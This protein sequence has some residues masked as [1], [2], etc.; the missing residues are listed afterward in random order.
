MWTLYNDKKKEPIWPLIPFASWPWLTFCKW[1]FLELDLTTT[2]RCT[3]G[4][5]HNKTTFLRKKRKH[6]HARYPLTRKGNMYTHTCVEVIFS[7]YVMLNL[8]LAQPIIKR[9]W[10]YHHMWHLWLEMHCMY[11]NVGHVYKIKYVSNSFRNMYVS[12]GKLCMFNNHFRQGPYFR[13]L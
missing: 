10:E 5:V 4:N 11:M 1:T 9:L 7:W 6:K 2:V 13:N 8:C 3:I 12:I